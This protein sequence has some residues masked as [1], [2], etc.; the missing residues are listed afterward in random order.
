MS[1]TYPPLVFLGLQSLQH[2]DLSHNRIKSIPYGT[3][4]SV[5]SLRD[6]RLDN[7]KLKEILGGGLYNLYKLYL[8]SNAL[9]TIKSNSLLPLTLTL[10]STQSSW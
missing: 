1:P 2:L 9:T 5:V 4:K 7:N 6:S 10:T 8:H 3:F